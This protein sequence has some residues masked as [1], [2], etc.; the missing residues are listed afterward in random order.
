MEKELQDIGMLNV[1]MESRLTGY[2]EALKYIRDLM[3]SDDERIFMG[4]EINRVE[5]KIEKMLDC[6]K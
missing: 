3:P 5:G 1:S 6:K 4:L 2:L